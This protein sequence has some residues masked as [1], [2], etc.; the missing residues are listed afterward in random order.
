MNRDAL[1]RMM[2]S[3]VTAGD[4]PSDELPDVSEMSTFGSPEEIITTAIDVS[5]FLGTTRASTAA[6]ASQLSE[7]SFFLSM[8][9]E[10]FV[11]SFGTEG[12]IL[13]GASPGERGDDLFSSTEER[14]DWQEG[15]RPFGARWA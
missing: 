13:R 3:A 9:E 12:F 5:E 7:T 8:Q 15:V 11:V 2:E 4:M 10:D 6:H 1:R 14:R